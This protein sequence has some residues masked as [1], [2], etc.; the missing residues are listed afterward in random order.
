[1]ETFCTAQLVT[2]AVSCSQRSQVTQHIA[3][4]SHIE[5]KNRKKERT[6]YQAFLTFPSS[7]KSTLSTDLCRALVRADISF[8]KLKNPHFKGFIETY[9]GKKMPDESTLRKNYL[10]DIYKDTVTKIR[11]HI[12][13]GPIWVSI[14]ETTDVEGRMKS[15]MPIQ[16]VVEVEAI[17]STTCTIS[18][19]PA[20][21]VLDTVVDPLVHSFTF[22]AQLDSVIWCFIITIRLFL[23]SPFQPYTISVFGFGF[24][25]RV[26]RHY[27]FLIILFYSNTLLYSQSLFYTNVLYTIDRL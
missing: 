18:T 3:T 6:S 15:S 23:R 4:G 20:A 7:S 8:H 9:I 25:T 22:P 12:K 16:S 10:E 1:M 19:A 26:G 13:D 17:S 24:S 5:N 21:D 2:S 14:D 27:I 11:E